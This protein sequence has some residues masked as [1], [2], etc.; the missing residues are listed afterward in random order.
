MRDK[1]LLDLLVD[2]SEQGDVPLHMP[3]H[4]RNEDLFQMGNPYG[5]DITEIDGFDN[6]HNARGIIADEF[7]RAAALFGA[8][9]TLFLVNGSSSGNM[10]AICGATNKGD[11]VIVARNIHCSVSNAIYLNELN[12][13]YVY[14]DINDSMCICGGISAEAVEKAFSENPDAKAVI[15]TSPTYEGVVSDIGGI[16]EITHR[17]GGVLIVDEAHG[18]HFNFSDAF[19]DSAV[20]YGADA[21]IQSIHK[22]LPAFTQT[23]LLHLNGDKI[24]RQRVKMYWNM[25]QSTSPS[26]I[27][28]AGISRCLTI[29]ERDGA[30]LF[31][32]YVKILSELRKKL[33]GLNYIRLIE[34]DDI[35]KIVLMVSDG[36]RIYDE[37]H[38]KYGIQLEMA[39]R[40]YVIA[41]TS[42]GDKQEYYDRFYKA[43]KQLDVP[44]MK[45]E[46]EMQYCEKKEGCGAFGNKNIAVSEKGKTSMFNK[47]PRARVY[48]NC[49]R[50]L[51]SEKETVKVGDS[52][53][54][55]AGAAICF[56]P[57]GIN[58]VNPGEVITEEIIDIITDGLR[59]GL[60]VIG[61]ETNGA[62][63]DENQRREDKCSNLSVDAD[64]NY[65]E[66]KIVCLK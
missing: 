12:P 45:Y 30:A 56:Y 33:S 57:P 24:D 4:K 19:P 3:G 11:K 42:V 22:T 15:V 62:A 40:N 17:Y 31:D 35:S 55:I 47:M 8:E 6:L 51:N 37:L 66:V 53:G 39:S 25:F 21:V 46:D 27:L 34:T 1:D 7:K 43:L 32:G 54:R 44:D 61:V 48:V 41:M 60:E 14:P 2:L 23:A 64:Y 9:E 20:K 28:M 26:Y 16:A 49:Y 58:L 18:A 36:K 50:A 29:L 10:A 5:L 13:V 38:K 63:A 59:Q 65:S 52:A